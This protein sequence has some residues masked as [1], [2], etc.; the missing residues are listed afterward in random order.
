M[1]CGGCCFLDFPGLLLASTLLVTVFRLC[2]I[3][4]LAFYCQVLLFFLSLTIPIC[5]SSYNGHIF[6]VHGYLFNTSVVNLGCVTMV[7]LDLYLVL[8]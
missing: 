6:S 2:P 7:V 5:S 8:P 4:S 3:L 1:R